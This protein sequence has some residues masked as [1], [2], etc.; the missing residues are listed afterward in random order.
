MN[1]RPHALL[2]SPFFH[3]EPI[4]TGRY[5]THLAEHL[6]RNGYDVTVACSHPL[7]PRWQP[8]R[9]DA[10]LPG[11]RVLR[12]GAQVR[13]P[14]R[15]VLRRAVLELWFAWH[16]A[17]CLLRLRGRID[18]V[19]PVFPPSCFAALA[20]TFSR[21]PW[22]G[23]VHDLQGTFA[24][25]AGGRFAR[26]VAAFVHRI[27]RRAFNG[28]RSLVF[29]SETMR[30]SAIAQYGLDPE[31]CQVIYPGHNVDESAPVDDAL[32]RLLPP[33]VHHVVYAGA[34]GHK[35]NPEGIA[36]LLEALALSRTDVRCHIFSAG[37]VFDAMRADPD[38]SGAVRFHDLVDEASLATLMARSTVQLISEVPGAGQ[39]AL[40]SKLAN[41]LWMAVPTYC[42]CDAGSEL[43]TLV[44]RSGI[45][46]VDST[47]ALDTQAAS[48][49]DFVDVAARHDREQDRLRLR[50]ACANLFSM[51]K[52]PEILDA[53]RHVPSDFE[54]A[55]AEACE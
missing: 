21:V 33:G 26:A 24:G 4:S 23:V 19:V 44:A 38:R 55:E 5:N 39:A 50:A 16:A 11:V 40:P 43:A 53:A 6:A 3:P 36:R 42:V 25:S 18:V 47:F 41:L 34:L 45:G 32:V 14:T 28:C 13:Y 22:V 51:K 27:E 37:P 35:Q 1:R 12:G 46:R 31:R 9:S 49:S 10:T 15:M 7:Y 30:R 17:V 54:T 8:A 29:L 52:I 48:L 2:L 20:L